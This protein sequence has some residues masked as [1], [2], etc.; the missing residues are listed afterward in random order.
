MNDPYGHEP[1]SQGTGAYVD[2]LGML[3]VRWDYVS[4]LGLIPG[5]D[6]WETL[7]PLKT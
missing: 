2:S 7:P 6:E 1:G 3:H 4:N 5:E